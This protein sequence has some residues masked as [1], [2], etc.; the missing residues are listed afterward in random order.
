MV[1]N[2]K[3]SSLSFVGGSLPFCVGLFL[4]IGAEAGPPGIVIDHIPAST[5]I[6]IGSPSLAVLTNGD[7]VASHDQ[8]GP[9]SSEH[10]RALSAV[11]RSADR[12]K[13]W[14]KISEIDGQFW[15]T[16]FVHHGLLYVFGTDKHHGDAIIRQ[17][18][19]G[20]MTWTSPTNSLS[21]LLRGGGQHHCAPMPVLEH[22]GRLW[23]PMERRDP[24]QGWG[25]TYCAGMLSVPVNSDLLDAS[26]WTVS[27]FLPGSTNWLENKFGGWLEGNPVLTR[28]GEMLDILRVDT[29]GYP[30]KAA[31]VRVSTDGRTMSFA[32]AT[33]FINFPGGAKKFAI[34]FDPE[35]DLYWSLATLVPES[36]QSTN[37]PAR[38][39]NT[40]GLVS[41]RDLASWTTRCILLH[42]PEVVKHG[43]QY[44]DWLFDGADMIAA[45]RTAFDDEEGGA[46][47]NHDANFLTFHRFTNFRSLTMADSVPVAAVPR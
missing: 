10:T 23:R 29:P 30:E 12:G 32:P 46:H 19:D 9:K 18:T 25:I 21:G 1:M 47:N 27:N 41:S 2:R 33:G 37:R 42:H 24:P 43:F 36:F 5:G 44:V 20:G 13:S 31:T 3:P 40:L 7:Y 34:R 45:C 17:S 28:A 22:R 16:L 35:S 39:R 15:S 6:Y 11:F 38:V 8:F 26:S 14:R 4:C